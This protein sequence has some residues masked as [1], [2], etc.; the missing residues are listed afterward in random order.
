MKGINSGSWQPTTSLHE[1]ILFK[2]GYNRDP[3]RCLGPEE[4]GEMLKEVHIRECGEY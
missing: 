3:L 2:K 1:E 4:A